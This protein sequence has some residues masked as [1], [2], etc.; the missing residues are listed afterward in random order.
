MLLIS[1]ALRNCSKSAS[2]SENKKVLL[3]FELF[4]PAIIVFS[5]TVFQDFEDFIASTQIVPFFR[6]DLEMEGKV[7]RKLTNRIKKYCV[8]VFF[9][10]V[11]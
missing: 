4:F 10:T 3:T 5:Q 7:Y 1:S 2:K 9:N 6:G 11:N 8:K